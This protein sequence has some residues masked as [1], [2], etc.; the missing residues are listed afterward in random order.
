MSR[1]SQLSYAEAEQVARER[2]RRHLEDRKR[3]SSKKGAFK[4]RN[5]NKS[6]EKGR[7]VMNDFEL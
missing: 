1:I 3:A 5:S 2:V 7:R 6:Y 4:T